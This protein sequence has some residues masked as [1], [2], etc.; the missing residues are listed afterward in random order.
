[1]CIRRAAGANVQVSANGGLPGPRWVAAGLGA[2]VGHL[3][4]AAV[5][6]LGHDVGA[7]LLQLGVR[8]RDARRGRHDVGLLLGEAARVAR[9][10]LELAE[11]RGEGADGRAGHGAVLVPAPEGAV[12]DLFLEE[13][14]RDVGLVGPSERDVVDRRAR[15][16]RIVDGAERRRR[17]R[18]VRVEGWA[19]LGHVV[20]A[21]VEGKGAARPALEGALDRGLV[22]ED[23]LGRVLDQRA[24]GKVLVVLERLGRERDKR[25]LDGV[26]RLGRAGELLVVVHDERLGRADPLL[27]H[28]ARLVVVATGGRRRVEDHVVF[29][30]EAVVEVLGAHLDHA[31]ARVAQRLG[32]DVL[33]V[34][35]LPLGILESVLEL[36]A[37][38]PGARG[39]HDVDLRRRAAEVLIGFVERPELLRLVAL[40]DV[41]GHARRRELGLDGVDALRPVPRRLAVALLELVVPREG[42]VAVRDPLAVALDDEHFELG[43]VDLGRVFEGHADRVAVELVLAGPCI[44]Q[45]HA[46]V[47]E[48]ARVEAQVVRLGAQQPGAA[49]RHEA[50]GGNVAGD[51]VGRGGAG[52]GAGRLLGDGER[53]R[54]ER[55]ARGGAAAGAAAGPVEVGRHALAPAVC[56]GPGERPEHHLRD[57]DG[58]A[59]AERDDGARL[60]VLHILC[61]EERAVHRRLVVDLV[62][63]LDAKGDAHERAEGDAIVEEHVVRRSLGERGDVEWRGD[64]AQV[65]VELVEAVRERLHD[66][67]AADAFGLD[68]RGDLQDWHVKQ[69]RGRRVLRGRDFGQLEFDRGGQ[70][71]RRGELE[72]GALHVA[73][74]RVVAGV[75]E[76]KG[77]LGVEL[78]VNVKARR[79]GGER[80]LALAGTG[81]EAA[82]E[83]AGGTADAGQRDVHGQRRGDQVAERVVQHQRVDLRRRRRRRHVRLGEA[84]RRLDGR[85]REAE[86][87]R[88]RDRGRQ[89]QRLHHRPV[90][91]RPSRGDG[92]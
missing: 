7:D 49:A 89:H 20:E 63:V 34:V 18:A 79:V 72:A 92:H 76:V 23:D 50:V 6:H 9:D 24:D 85:L 66:G 83:A 60:V 28:A 36:L 31:E 12:G 29:V 42:A 21:L 11:R 8:E 26:A 25:A 80:L 39:H 47:R 5:G 56:R 40:R 14:G 35:S 62:V 22:G 51:E 57:G 65:R 77:G 70:V 43:D 59:L 87:V 16:A 81:G 33:W 88:A 54:A 3:V 15:G 41:K 19:R 68:Q 90:R 30:P 4:R 84:D 64:D 44:V 32:R 61:V 52:D 86:P 75:V 71:A 27:E 82:V 2:Y 78:V 69:V 48:E 91:P 67:D 73:H 53:E 37:L 10:A 13:V 46:K 38:G 1:M 55:R 58:A 17:R 74:E 45:N